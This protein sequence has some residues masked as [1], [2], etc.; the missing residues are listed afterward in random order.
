MGNTQLGVSSL[1]AASRQKGRLTM[2]VRQAQTEQKAH[3]AQGRGRRGEVASDEWRES[4]F[5]REER[6][7]TRKLEGKLQNIRASTRASAEGMRK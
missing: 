4:A 7:A 6:R 5:V 3:C 1:K 2:C